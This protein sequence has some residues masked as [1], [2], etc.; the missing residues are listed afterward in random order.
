MYNLFDLKIIC[1]IKIITN[2]IIGINPGYVKKLFIISPFNN[3][4]NALCAP[5]P[6]QSK[7]KFSLIG[8]FCW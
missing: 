7:P 6:K 5:Q 1:K 8:H 4:I 2:I 3:K